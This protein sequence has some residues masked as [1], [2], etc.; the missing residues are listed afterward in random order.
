M[1]TGRVP[2]VNPG[3]GARQFVA[4]RSCVPRNVQSRV[5]VGPVNQ[6]IFEDRIRPGDALR[7][8]HRIADF[9]RHLRKRNI[10]CAQ[11]V[12]VPGIK[13]EVLKTVGL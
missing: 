4:P 12:A 11:A 9:A 7:N 1:W 6:A 13:D 10:D 5:V 8:R 3:A 2:F